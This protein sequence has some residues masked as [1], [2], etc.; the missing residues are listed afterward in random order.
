M[1]DICVFVLFCF[2][3]CFCFFHLWV[4]IFSSWG[5]SPPRDWNCLS[6]ASCFGRQFL[7]HYCTW[8]AHS[9]QKHTKIE[10][11]SLL[12]F[13]KWKITLFPKWLQWLKNPS[14]IQ[15]IQERW[16]RSLDQDYPLE[17]EMPTQN[18]ILP[19]KISWTEEHGRLQLVGSQRV[20]CDNRPGD[21]CLVTQ[22]CLTL[23]DPRDCG[24]LVPPARGV[25][26]AR[27]LKGV[28]ISFS[29][30]LVVL[31]VNIKIK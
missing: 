7:Y 15:E 8:E 29:M 10:R 18:S 23:C 14:A 4:A 22:S 6:S 2:F 27:I 24:S 12:I 28:A 11:N 25:S 13:F 1:F 26:Q 9:D 5:F 20:A 3:F 16:V 19:R 30:T 31:K 21:A 17:Q